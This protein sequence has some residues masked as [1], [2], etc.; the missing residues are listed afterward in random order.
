MDVSFEDVTAER[1]PRKEH[2]PRTPM[3]FTRD[4]ATSRIDDSGAV[5]TG[6]DQTIHMLRTDMREVKSACFS[7]VCRP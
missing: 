6:S 7:Y 5:Y 1:G 2:V 4:T 3:A